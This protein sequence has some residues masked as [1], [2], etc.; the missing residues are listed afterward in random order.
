MMASLYHRIN[1]EHKKPLHSGQIAIARALFRDRKTIIQAQLG[2]NCGKSEIA[3]YCAWVYAM[4][5]PG[6][7][8][9]II[10]PQR[11]QGKEIYWA[12]GR[13]KYYGP[14]EYLAG[15]PKE[16]ELRLQFKNGSFICVEGA[17]N[18][19]A[20]RGIKPDLVIYD[21]FQDHIKEF[22]VEVMRPNLIA[23]R[24][25]LLVFG[26]PPKR[27]GYYYEFKKQL[28]KQVEDGDTTRMYLQLPTS[29]NPSIN[30]EELAKIKKALIAQGDE[31]VWKREYLAEDCIG[32]AEM[33]FPLWSRERYVKP[34]SL[35][36]SFLEKARNE[37]RFGWISDP[38]STSTFAC[39]FVAY[40]PYTCQLFVLD[41]I[42]EQDRRRTDTKSIW[43]VARP[44]MLAINPDLR[45]WRKIADEA[46]AWFR[47]E[48]S[49]NFGVS[50]GPSRK[51]KHN[52]EENISVVK[53]LMAQDESFFVSDRCVKF[54]W[55]I[56]NY[57]TDD[58]GVLPDVNDHLMDCLDYSIPAL[59]VRTKEKVRQEPGAPLFVSSFDRRVRVKSLSTKDSDWGEQV[60]E[61]SLNYDPLND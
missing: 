42:Y 25:S 1:N 48:M 7:Q 43:D 14:P 17:E 44:K 56:E 22:D 29:T 13:L 33:V 58:A 35:L 52:K 47:H 3:L 18:Y 55:E 20:L 53:M 30:K 39:L 32:G 37:L 38:G 2:R 49:A 24:A 57:A 28:L 31:A 26:T 15:E 60:F 27:D 34:H 40:N 41:E 59:T 23:K 11:K 36:L 4:T 21:E 61:D 8:V 51:R 46:A 54:M 50:I 6:S 19:S 16:S 9:Y 10:C 5:N 12:S 45:E